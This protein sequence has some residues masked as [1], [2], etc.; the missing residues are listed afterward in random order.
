PGFLAA[1]RTECDRVGALLIFDEVITGFRVDVGGAQAKYDVRP[2]ITCFGKVIGGGLPIGAIGG[3][4]EV[5]EH[6]SPLG[7]VF[8]AGTL[9]GNPLATAAGLAALDELTP[10]V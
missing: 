5:M 9:S 8:H 1:L 3:S 2:D 4:V 10:D 6:L 7:P